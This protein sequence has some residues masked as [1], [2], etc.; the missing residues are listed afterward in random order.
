[1]GGHLGHRAGHDV[2][3]GTHLEGDAVAVEPAHQ[4]LVVHAAH[5]VADA[6]GAEHL[7]GLPDAGR[8]GGLSGV[9]GHRD[10]RGMGEVERLP[11][12]RSGV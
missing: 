1:M 11:V 5:A 9:D 8:A 12:G 10:A 3:G 6:P 2:A 4:R 7:D